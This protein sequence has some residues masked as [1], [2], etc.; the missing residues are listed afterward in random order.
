MEET[1]AADEADDVVR[2]PEVTVETTRL[3]STPLPRVP[4]AAPK[5]DVVID[6]FLSDEGKAEK[7]VEKH[8][9]AFDRLVLNRFNIFGSKKRR[10]AEAEAREQ[11]ARGMNDVADAIEQADAWGKTEEEK[12][13]LREEYYQLLSNAPK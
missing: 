11:F 9:T 1:A 7:L 2:L 4:V 12:A 3:P 13:K 6:E 10:A 5:N 8:L